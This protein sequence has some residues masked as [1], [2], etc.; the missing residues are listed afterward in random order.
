[1][2]AVKGVGM[3][4][5]YAAR[6]PEQIRSREVEK[7]SVGAWSTVLVATFETDPA[8]LASVLPRPLEPSSTSLAKVTFASVDIPGM[9]T[10]GAGSVSVQ[11]SHEGTLGYYCLV[12][13]MSTEQSVIGGRETFGEP[14]KL[15]QVA[16]ELEGDSVH[17]TMTRMGITFAEFTGHITETLD[18]PATET[19]TD[20][21]F[22]A[23]PAPDGK[24][25]DADP[26][27]VYCTR[28]ETV[29]WVK[30]CDGEL[31]LRD[32]RFD[33]VADL[34]IL[35]LAEVTVGERN[36]IQRGQIHSK[37]PAEWIVPFMHQRYDDPSPTGED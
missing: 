32:S 21:Y 12:M 14:K 16:V 19:R 29:R 8:I 26:S 13:P 7:T 11:C 15:G 30:A 3:A 34:P 22:K 20:F 4:V 28:E 35:S 24:G 27:L 1:M 17:G 33:P 9:A 2:P 10:F 18:V 25:L 36:A 31:D 6:T 5:R 37:V 23:L